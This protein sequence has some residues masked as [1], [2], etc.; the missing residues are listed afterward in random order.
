MAN[1][2][3]EVTVLAGV[4]SLATLVAGQCGRFLCLGAID[5]PEVDWGWSRGVWP[6]RG[7]HGM[8]STRWPGRRTRTECVG[9]IDHTVGCWGYNGMP[10]WPI[11]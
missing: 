9:V 3:M 4:A 5:V 7:V 11:N 1:V 6:C 8:R 2:M 10:R